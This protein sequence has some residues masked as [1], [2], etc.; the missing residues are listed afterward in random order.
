MHP[1]AYTFLYVR[2]TFT[3]TRTWDRILETC[4]S[5]LGGGEHVLIA[6][7]TSKAGREME[8]APQKAG[9]QKQAVVLGTEG[10]IDPCFHT[11]ACN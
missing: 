4:G 7:V 9:S 1:Y 8:K 5:L 10:Q 11:K 3:N 2:I 6:H